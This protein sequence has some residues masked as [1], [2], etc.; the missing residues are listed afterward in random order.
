MTTAGGAH[1]LL[2]LGGGTMGSGIAALALGHG[3]PVTLVE[4][5]AARLAAASAA[6]RTKVR[7]AQ[8]M[9]ALPEGRSPAELTGATEIP[10][11]AAA[12]AVIEAVTENAEDK[13]K[14]LTA[15]MAAVPP[16]TPVISN[17]SGIPIDE[18]ARWLPRPADLVGAH[19]MNPP[20]LIGMT[21]VARG[22]QTGGRTLEA[23]RALLAGLGRTPVVVRDAPGFVTS[24]LLHPMIN[25]A[26]RLVGEGTATAEQVDALMRGCLGH[27]TGPLRTAD[28]IG[29]DNLADSLGA[30][31]ER[32]G[33]PA[34]RPCDVL[35]DMVR[36]GD[37]G[38]KSGR[39]FFDYREAS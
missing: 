22:P 13:A 18:M 14:A 5:D 31:Y 29:L 26:A 28:L 24:R 11:P 7:H 33:D 25:S 38:R 10:A 6:V 30:L 39:G 8:L 34:C 1:R 4:V 35:L 27:P 17:T 9:D 37:L 20:Y 15:A 12:T 19:F 23:V 21:E 32:T 2:V 16:G 36:R 3:V